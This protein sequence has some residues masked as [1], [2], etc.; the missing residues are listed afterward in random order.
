MTGLGNLAKKYDVNIQV[1]QIHKSI[2]YHA[3][4]LIY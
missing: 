4:P 3:L 1:G 2:L